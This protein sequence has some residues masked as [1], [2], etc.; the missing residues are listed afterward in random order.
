M[1]SLS[2]FEWLST[3]NSKV[4]TDEA[5]DA[6]VKCGLGVKCQNLVLHLRK[7]TK[8]AHDALHT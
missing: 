5:K 4:A 7:A 6:I 3:F 8:L 1:E 2:V